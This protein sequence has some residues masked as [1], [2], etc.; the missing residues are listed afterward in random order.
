M[1]QF[2]GSESR[3]ATQSSSQFKFPLFKQAVVSTLGNDGQI[4]AERSVQTQSLHRVLEMLR[5]TLGWTKK[6]IKEKSVWKFYQIRDL[7]QS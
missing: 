6:L 7:G 3:T 1:L 4:F 5:Q 2:H